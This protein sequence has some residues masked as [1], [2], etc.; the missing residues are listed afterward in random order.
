M[1]RVGTVPGKPGEGS[2]IFHRQGGGQRKYFRGCD[3]QAKSQA[4]KPQGREHRSQQTKEQDR[5]A[6]NVCDLPRK[7]SPCFVSLYST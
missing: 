1:V 5:K 6:R 2:P 7:S 4:A 3:A